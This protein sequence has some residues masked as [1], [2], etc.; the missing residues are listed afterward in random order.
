[1][2]LGIPVVEL[3]NVI[4][5]TGVNGVLVDNWDTVYQLGL[6]PAL[7]PEEQDFNDLVFRIQRDP[8][9]MHPNGRITCQ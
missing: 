7:S 6:D 9:A 1:M 3:L 8:Q 5:W 2:F 4:Q